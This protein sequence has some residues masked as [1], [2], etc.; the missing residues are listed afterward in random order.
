MIKR[1]IFDID[2]T[3]IPWKEEYFNE[4]KIE[5]KN[6]GIAYTENDYKKIRKAFAEYE[7]QYYIFDRK[8]MINY[9]NKYTGKQYPEEFIYNLTKNWSKCI[10]NKLDNG[11]VETLQYL[12]NK[13]EIVILT[14]WFEDQQKERLRR[15]GILKYFSKIYSAEKTKRK[16]FKE[17]FF[18]AIGEN[19]PEE[20][21]MIGDSIERDI[22][23]ALNSG[24]KAIWFNPNNKENKVDCTT[25]DKI[26][27]LINIL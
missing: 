12:I 14:D 1:I 25:I 27:E 22:E 13:Y 4:I 9:I 3:L 21:V 15:I 23:G 17:A 20:C 10:P 16:P 19:K 6:L 18:R 7:N 24:L 11:V 5:L 8:L 2:N 26:E